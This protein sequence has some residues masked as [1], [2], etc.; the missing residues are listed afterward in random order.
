[1]KSYR[2]FRNYTQGFVNNDIIRI[3]Y[4]FEKQINRSVNYR[5]K[6]KIYWGEQVFLSQQT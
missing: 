6:T 1:M 2:L 5:L 4:P 3:L